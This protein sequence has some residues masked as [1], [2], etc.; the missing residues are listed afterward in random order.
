MDSLHSTI[1]LYPGMSRKLWFSLSPHQTSCHTGKKLNRNGH[2]KT[3][4]RRMWRHR[5]EIYQISPRVVW[6]FL[7]VHIT[8]LVMQHWT[9]HDAEFENLNE[10][11]VLFDRSINRLND[12]LIHSFIH[13]F[14]HPSIHP[15]THP[16]IHQS[17]HSLMTQPSRHII[18]V[19]INL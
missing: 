18:G 8:T 10:R 2:N 19:R 14:I 12:P 4:L 15:S 16:S 6:Y 7:A 1:H 17:V 13:S 11:L 9:S 3:P 5:F